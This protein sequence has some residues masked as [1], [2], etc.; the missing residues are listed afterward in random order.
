MKQMLWHYFLLWKLRL[1][2]GLN[3]TGKAGRLLALAG[4]FFSASPAVVL[5]LTFFRLMRQP[6]VMQSDTWPDFIVRM[7]S[8]IT[9]SVWVT[10]P[11]MSAGV[12]DHSE[13]S[14]YA[15]L[16]ISSFRLMA[17][18][19][20]AS[21]FEPRSIVFYAPL[22][23]ATLGY[24]FNYRL[25]FAWM[26]PVAFVTYV[27]FNAA[28]SRLALHAMLSV[29][30]Q[31]QSAQLLGSG[32]FIFLLL[33]SLIPPVDT[34]WLTNLQLAGVAAVPDSLIENATLALG[35]FPTGLFAHLL[36]MS[37]LNEKLVAVQDWVFLSSLTLVIFAVAYGLLL[38]FNKRVSRGVATSEA[39]KAHNP[40]V[41]SQ[42]ILSTLV[43]REARD[44][45]LNP[46]A[47]L[48]TAV[49]FV[50]GILLKLLSA[51]ALIAFL[52]PDNANAWLLTG[53]SL[54]GAL[55]LASTFS[56]NAFAY[57]GH[58]LAA[59]MAAPIELKQVLLAKNLVHAL[60]GLTL[61]LAVML[62]YAL[63]FR[64]G[65]LVDY[66]FAL[67]SVLTFLPVSLAAG[68]ALSLYFPVKFH[69]NLKRK[70]RLPFL[71]SMAGIAAAS[72]G[73]APTAFLLRR[74]PIDGV[75]LGL[76]AVCAAFGWMLLAV[77]RRPTAMV[78][79]LRKEAVLRAVTRE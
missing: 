4:F 14:R 54:Y 5:A 43:W 77:S 41:K 47:R 18:S 49:P 11:L 68:N 59:L 53:L 73:T 56:Q 3:R 2:I 78:L 76:L 69:A 37:T 20:V 33:A 70:D 63:Y 58:G 38:D 12:D 16:P 25:Y 31:Q 32:F 23:G 72:A 40:F 10:W 17:A 22:A 9:T 34:S 55:V 21:L 24:I 7:L 50:L 15:H 75:S 28:L 13:L 79:G 1:T 51:N 44:L 46:R 67:L 61:A 8:F 36:T 27:A 29:L 48:L 65:V 39:V 35:R 45:F 62:F 19:T 52:A 60:A 42:S 6:A 66:A 71:A 57:D 74:G 64:L 26:I 30:R